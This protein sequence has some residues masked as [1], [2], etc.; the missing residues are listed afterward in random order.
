MFLTDL[1]TQPTYRKPG[2][3]RFNP[4]PIDLS[5]RLVHYIQRP[6]AEATACGL[7]LRFHPSALVTVNR[8]NMESQCPYCSVAAWLPTKE[9]AMTRAGI[10]CRLYPD[11][12]FTAHENA[13]SQNNTQNMPL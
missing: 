13:P 4:S 9:N 5:A 7:L 8:E 10:D 2:T 1:A 3:A 11:S 12:V 6:N